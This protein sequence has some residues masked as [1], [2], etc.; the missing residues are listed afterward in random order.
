MVTPFGGIPLLLEVIGR[1]PHP[2]E[3]ARAI[4][5]GPGQNFG[6]DCAG[7]MWAAGDKL[8]ILGSYGYLP[9]ELAGLSTLDLNGDYP[10]ADAFWEGEAIIVPT[11]EV[12][13]RYTSPRR[14]DSRWQRFKKRFEGGDHVNASIHS[15]GRPIGGFTLNCRKARVWSTLDIAC[16]D[17]ISHYLGMW[18]THPDSGVPLELGDDAVRDL[19][20]SARQ[21][22]ILKLVLEGRTNTSIAHAL[23]ISTSTVKQDLSRVMGLL[24]A[25]DRRTAAQRADER[26][27]LSAGE[28]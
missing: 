16:L 9:D 28:Q 23:G 17:A 8:V 3:V 27:L 1:S 15:D 22:Q 19:V 18:L 14:P 5:E 2:D 7:V 6:A 11:S 13:E 25:T 21:R 24:D 12:E 26:G 20:L 4:V 10:M